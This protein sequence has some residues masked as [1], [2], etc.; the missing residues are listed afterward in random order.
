MPS[1][2]LCIARTEI[3]VYDKF[4]WNSIPVGEAVEVKLNRFFLPC[5]LV[6]G[7]EGDH[8]GFFKGSPFVFPA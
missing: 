7:H 8:Q 1:P 2:E 6:A 5:E 3:L 4:D